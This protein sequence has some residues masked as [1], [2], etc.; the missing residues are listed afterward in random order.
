MNRVGGKLAV[1][2]AFGDYK[3][4]PISRLEKNS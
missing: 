3:Y 2:R 1:S 4:K